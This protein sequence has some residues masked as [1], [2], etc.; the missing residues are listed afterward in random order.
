ML[1]R[2]HEVRTV[3]GDMALA[4]H[5]VRR[6]EFEQFQSAPRAL[7]DEPITGLCALSASTRHDM[8]DHDQLRAHRRS[9]PSLLVLA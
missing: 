3:P 1:G 4:G 6:F 9:A 8:S 7:G 5:A 2:G